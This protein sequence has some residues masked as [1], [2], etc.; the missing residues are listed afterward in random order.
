MKTA[1]S[2]SKPIQRESSQQLQRRDVAA[3]VLVVVFNVGYLN[4]LSGWM[5]DFKPS[6]L[7]FSQYG[8]GSGY[9]SLHGVKE[10]TNKR[11]LFP[12][13]DLKHVLSTKTYPD[14]HDHQLNRDQH[15]GDSYGY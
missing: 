15:N 12:F 13:E 1:I 7:S 14:I 6:T 11:L 10:T 3:I 8:L 4:K 5:Q 2:T 9:G